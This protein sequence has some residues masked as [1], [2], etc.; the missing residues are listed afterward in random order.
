MSKI[1]KGEYMF[2][3]TLRPADIEKG[4]KVETRITEIKQ[5]GTKYGDKRIA[6]LE[7]GQQIFLNAMSL[8]NLVKAFEDETEKWVGKEIVMEVE[9]SERTQGKPSIV[10]SAKK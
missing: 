10:V 9:I 8:Q 4:K 2:A 3:D 6:V 5:I 7:T 1:D